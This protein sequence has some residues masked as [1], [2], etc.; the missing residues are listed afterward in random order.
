MK[1][2]IF[3][4]LLVTALCLTLT[5]AR[6]AV[7]DDGPTDLIDWTVRFVHVSQM[8]LEEENAITG[9]DAQPAFR[10]PASLRF[11]EDEA[12]EGTAIV[13]IDLPETVESIG[14]NAFANIPTLRSVKIPE[15]TKKIARTS[16]AGSSNVM[17][18]GTPGSYARTY[19]RE[20][21]LPFSPVTVVYAGTGSV[22]VSEAE[23]VHR[24]RIDTDTNDAA[25]GN[26]AAPQWRPAEE[27]K[28]EQYDQCIA[29][30]IVGRAPPAFA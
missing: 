11:I 25:E 26:D 28:T 14:E 29:H 10:L 13:S 12:F 8:N 22:Q 2:Y 7:R 21:G 3:M 19:A 16:F 18:T 17:I 20:N 30:S 9:A 27:S 24:T 4:S 6:A 1:K 15:N 5:C 23:S